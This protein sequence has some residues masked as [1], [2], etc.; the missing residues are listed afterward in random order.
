M[1]S[2]GQTLIMASSVH[3]PAAAI[4][5]RS[6]SETKECPFRRSCCRCERLGGGRCRDGGGVVDASESAAAAAAAADDDD[7]DDDDGGGNA[8]SAAAAAAAAGDAGDGSSP[9][10]GTTPAP[11]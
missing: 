3:L 5:S 7:D 11:P 4:A 10:E 2:V 9:T 8:A 1:Y 6:A